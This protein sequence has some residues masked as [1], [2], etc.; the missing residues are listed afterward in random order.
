M[1]VYIKGGNFDTE[2]GVGGSVIIEA[3]SGDVGTTGNVEISAQQTTIDSND[4]VWTFNDAGV[5]ELPPGGDIVDSDGNS[6]LGGAGGTSD[7]LVNGDLETVLD[8]SGT[9]NTPLLFPVTF[10]AVFDPTH[11]TDDPIVL[12]APFWEAEVQFQVNP[13]GEIQT[14]VSNA[15]HLINPGYE[16]GN[17]FRYT[18]ADHGIPG[19]TFEITLSDV[20]FV[21]VHWTANIQ[22]SVPPEYPSTIKSLGAIKLTANENSLIV[23]TGGSLYLAN[24]SAIN[25]QD[26]GAVELVAGPGVDSYSGL[27]YEYRNW[28][29]VDST[30][31]YIEA[32]DGFTGG[33]WSFTSD[34]KMRLPLGGD[35]VDNSGNS[36]LGG[37]GGSNLGNWAFSNNTMY[38][39]SGGVIDNSDQEHDATASITLP[40]NSSNNT[41][42]INSISG[43]QITTD[44]GT[45][46]FDKDGTLTF[47]DG[48]FQDTAFVGIANAIVAPSIAG[49]PYSVVSFGPENPAQNQW[50]GV[51]TVDGDIGWLDNGSQITISGATTPIEL[52][53]TWY[54]EKM[55]YISSGTFRIYASYPTLFSTEGW[56]GYTGG[57]TLLTL[58]IPQNTSITNNGNIWTFDT[59][60]TL[61]LP[62]GANIVHSDVRL[63]LNLD[64]GNA[65]YLT[66]TTDDT[67]ALYLTAKDVQLYASESVSLQSGTGTGALQTIYEELEGVWVLVREND[68]SEVAPTHR[69][70]EGMPSYEAYIELMNYVP[71]IGEIGILN[72]VQVAKTASD[73]YT[74]YNDALANSR[75]SIDAD[76]AVWQ[77]TPDNSLITPNYASIETATSLNITSPTV[78]LYTNHTWINMDDAGNNI[79]NTIQLVTNREIGTLQKWEFD[80]TGKLKLPNNTTIGNDLA[81]E[82]SDTF[83]CS[84]WGHADDAGLF[85]TNPARA[86]FNPRIAEVTVGWYVSGPLL[87]GIKQI[88]EIVEQGAG[89]RAFKVDLTDGSAWADIDVNIPYRLYT[90]D[91]ELVYNGTRLTVNSNNWNF[92]QSGDLTIPGDI[93]EAE[94]NDL[95]IAVHTLRTNYGTPGGA[96]LSLTN[97]DAV[98]GQTYTKLDVGAYDIKLNTDCEGNFT[99]NQHTWTFDRDGKLTMPGNIE[100]DAVNPIVSFPQNSSLSFN[101]T[102]SMGPSPST[103]TFTIGAYGIALQNGNGNIYSGTYGDTAVRWNLDSANKELTFPNGA[104]IHY[105]QNS[106]DIELFSY[107]N[108]IKITAGQTNHWTFGND[109]NLTFPDATVQETAF[110]DVPS[111]LFFVHP[112]PDRTFT[113]T[114]TYNSPFATITAAINAAVAA[115]HNDANSAVVILLANITENVTLAPGVYLT[116]LGTGTHGSPT[117]TGTVTVTS[118]S[119][120]TVTNH[121]SISNLRI[122][123]PTDGKAIYFTGTAPQKLFVRDMW[124]DAHGTGTGI[125]MDNTGSG[126]TL[127]MD[128]A[129]MYHD[130]SGD[131]YCID[132]VNGGC[133]VTDIETSGA[134]QVAAVRAGAVLTIDSSELDAVGDVVCETYGSGSVTITNSI[135]NNTQANGNGIKLNNAGGVATLGNNLIS[136]PVGSGYAVQGVSGTALYAANNVFLTANTARSTAITYVALPTTW[137]TKA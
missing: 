15:P 73:A 19:Y 82:Y 99:G 137:S 120:S 89:D 21:M 75:V 98:D 12:T 70:W 85:S 62:T 59:N 54:I 79:S 119:G 1:P 33:T 63:S 111:H 52:N 32:S 90:P 104:A 60:G 67:T 95:E 123:G 126:S 38:N 8:T 102:V 48:S 20:Q 127:Q 11:K 116:S 61:T 66:T 121:Y 129:H 86:G 109:G 55:P 26:T 14:M 40:A 113:A 74:A 34:G 31:A 58:D 27:T 125:Y 46:D 100:L 10:T 136:V 84:E 103:S 118:S 91:Y 80:G 128:I 133:Y 64:E 130:G 77:F 93:H 2:D 69:P 17:K 37:A 23:G 47:P 56:A 88:T 16:S 96:V 71:G 83:L 25:L 3:G 114:G 72:L 42:I 108:P 5:L 35:I 110:Q 122:V 7:R 29:W 124:I 78:G 81:G 117:I 68:A 87:N 107:T 106:S 92:A 49:T 36:V 65:A 53:G 13:N 30:A 115:G 105:D 43:V 57:A 9:L 112:N 51:V 41:T 39:L 45:W 6:V 44:A 22:C 131:I 134:T 28:I 4:N 101:T 97:Y 76:G 94:G 50:W 18:E 135:I 132:V 24:E